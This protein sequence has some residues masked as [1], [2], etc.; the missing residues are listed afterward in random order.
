[1]RKLILVCAALASVAL[2]GCVYRPYPYG[3]GY[4]GGGQ[5]GDRYDRGYGSGVYDRSYRGRDTYRRDYRDRRGDR[6]RDDD[7][8]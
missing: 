3:G 8:R 1:M 2:A 5:Y 6:D 7:D 4:Y